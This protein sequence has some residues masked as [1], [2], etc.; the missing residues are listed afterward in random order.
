M[1]TTE[2]KD[3][4]EKFEKL[5]GLKSQ[6]PCVQ[7]Q[8]F[9]CKGNDEYIKLNDIK[10]CIDKKLEKDFVLE[11]MGNESVSL[12]DYYKLMKGLD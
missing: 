2:T 10:F 4:I 3:Y 11:F 9:H 1:N 7:W 6:Y 5:T 8:V 12:Q